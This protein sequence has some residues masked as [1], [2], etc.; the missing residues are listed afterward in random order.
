MFT[1]FLKIS[2]FSILLL[3]S[4]CGGL[5]KS[6]EES[7]VY[8]ADKSL[9]STYVWKKGKQFIAIVRTIPVQGRDKERTIHPINISSVTIARSFSQLTYTISEK[10]GG[11]KKKGTYPVFF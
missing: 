4:S 3:I 2:F 1:N 7:G 6:W 8:T 5:K 9:D 10:K 11:G